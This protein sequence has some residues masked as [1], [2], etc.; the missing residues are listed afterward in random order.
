VL[1]VT[2]T[3]LRQPREVA[4]GIGRQSIASVT[5]T[6]LAATD[7]HAH[8]TLQEPTRVSPRS[9][10][11]KASGSTVVHSFPPA[12]VTRLVIDLA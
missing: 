7:V 5:A 2:N 1:T 10:P 3:D 6:V 9:A 4:I 8:N 12:S 11:A